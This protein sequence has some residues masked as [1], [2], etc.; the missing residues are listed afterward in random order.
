M[1][2]ITNLATTGNYTFETGS[3]KV[4]F[5]FTVYNETKSVIIRDGRIEENNDILCRTFSTDSDGKVTAW[6]IKKG[7]G[8]DCAHA[9]EAAI[10]QFE[11]K[12]VEGA[13]E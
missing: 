3:L 7:R 10:S 2:T 5:N 12:L 4:T 6:D 13:M 8:V 1:G 9:W 11:T